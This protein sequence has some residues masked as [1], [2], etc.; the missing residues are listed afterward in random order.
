MNAS[1]PRAIALL[2]VAAL[3]LAVAAAP[4]SGAK[5]PRCA[6]KRSTTVAKNAQV[7]LYV[8]RDGE[9]N[10]ELHACLRATGRKLLAAAEYDDGYVM[11][12]AYRDVRLAGRFVALVFDATDISCKAACPPDY[13][14]TKT[15]VTVRD[16]RTRRGRFSLSDA[17]PRSLRLSS[18]GVAAWLAPVAAGSEL[19][20]LDG[21]GRGRLV[22]TGA[23]HAATLALRGLQLSWTNAGAPKTLALTPF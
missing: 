5:R 18:T 22:D 8:V 14:A 21:A 12:G 4:A 2:L 9:G 3:A 23:I 15:Q 20:V 13:D 7:R 10:R 19:H 11:S 1:V 17:A 6:V 16:V